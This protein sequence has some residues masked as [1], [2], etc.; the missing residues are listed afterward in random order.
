MLNNK[1]IIHIRHIIDGILKSHLTY[2]YNN[3]SMDEIAQIY[4]TVT[5]NEFPTI[6]GERIIYETPLISNNIDVINISKNN[7]SLIMKW[8]IK[9]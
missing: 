4:T 5:N 8:A 7:N 1:K 3:L 9:D 6:E 2:T